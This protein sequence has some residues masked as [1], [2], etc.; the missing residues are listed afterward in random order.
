[1]AA[2]VLVHDSQEDETIMLYSADAREWIATEPDRYSLI[3]QEDKIALANPPQAGVRKPVDLGNEKGD[4]K[5]RPPA[6]GVRAK[7]KAKAD[8]ED[9]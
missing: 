3:N 5:P 6:P 8:K 4:D 7:G 1:V 2:K 9:D